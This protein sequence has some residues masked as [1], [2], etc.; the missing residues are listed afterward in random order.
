MFS[1]E[2]RVRQN[3]DGAVLDL[4]HAAIFKYEAPAALIETFRATWGVGP[5]GV[6]L[7]VTA[8]DGLLFPVEGV[9]E[10]FSAFS[11]PFAGGAKDFREV[12]YCFS[13]LGL[14]I[15]LLVDPTMPF[16]KTEALHVVDI[17]GDSSAQVCTSNPRAQEIVGAIL[18]T[19][20]DIVNETTKST[21]GKL[22]GVIIDCVDLL[23]M[24][25]RDERL[26][27]TCFCPSCEKYFNAQDPL[28]LKHFRTF[29]N[30]WNLLLKVGSTGIGHVHNIRANS[31]PEDV[32]GLCRQ[33][34]YHTVFEDKS[35]SA[36]L[37]HAD[38]LLEYIRA[39]HNL[40]VTSIGKMFREAL[41]GLDQQ[42]RR[43]ILGEGHQYDWTSGLVMDLLDNVD[44][45]TLEYFD[46]VWFNPSSTEICLERMPFRSYMWARSR[47]YIDSFFQL[48]A[49]ASDPSRRT[50]LGLGRLPVPKL[51]AL[52]HQRL[53][54][55]IAGAASGQ[56]SLA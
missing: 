56:T 44:G 23:P 7:P 33:K 52:L 25:G 13:Q 6:V 22:R 12:V 43:I 15:Y 9:G 26:E 34:N 37:G 50:T 47:Y 4:Q 30:P 39:R 42:P 11:G 32:V 31:T 28:I 10:P 40:I 41:E 55:A 14:D 18:G 29:P 38:A 49:N 5:Q 54:Q 45:S 21:K 27:L 51:K 2:K 1:I 48:A 19:G 35:T 20:I 46:E 24:G 3:L 16:N 53:N 36:L 8:P 17:V